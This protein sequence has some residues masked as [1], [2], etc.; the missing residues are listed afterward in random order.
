VI[1]WAYIERPPRTQSCRITATR[2]KWHV[3]YGR[4]LRAQRLKHQMQRLASAATPFWEYKVTIVNNKIFYLTYVIF[5]SINHSAPVLRNSLPSQ[6]R[7]VA[8]RHLLSTHLSL[9][10]QP[11][12]FLNSYKPIFFTVLFLLSLYSPR[13]HQD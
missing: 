2:R 9:I 11:L 5:Q 8:F 13:L 6:L 10:F 4:V 3:G 1:S 12:F 7:R